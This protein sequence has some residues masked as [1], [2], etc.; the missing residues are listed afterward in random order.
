MIK[1][2]AYSQVMWAINPAL[3]MCVCV[4]VSKVVHSVAGGIE[5]PGRGC[6]G[7]SRQEAYEYR[8]VTNTFLFSRYQYPSLDQLADM[9]PCILQYLKWEASGVLQ[10]FLFSIRKSLECGHHGFWADFGLSLS[11]SSMDFSPGL[12]GRAVGL[13]YWLERSEEAYY[14]SGEREGKGLSW[15]LSWA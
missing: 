1:K 13:D 10:T 11:S 9:I 7:Y 8:L 6:R 3:S 4:C 14:W 12:L 5:G 2:R 15:A